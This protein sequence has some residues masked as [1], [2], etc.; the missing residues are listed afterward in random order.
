MSNELSAP[1]PSPLRKNLRAEFLIDPDLAFLNHGSFGALPRVVFEEQTRW[2]LRIEADPIEILG[3][4]APKLIEEAKAS[5]GDWLGMKTVDFGLVTNATEGIN[6]V[7][8]SLTFSA[9]DE[10]LTT[11]HVYNAVRQAMKFAAARSGAAYREVNIP[12]PV[13]SPKAIEETILGAITSRTK[14]LVVDDI[15]SPTA[16][17]FPIENILAQCEQ[18]GVDVLIDGAHGPGMLARNIE[19]LSPAYY[20]GN[21]HKWACAPKGSA[22]LWV[23]KNR[24]VGIHPLVVSHFF[25]QG[26]S[27]EFGWQGTRDIASWLSVPRAIRYMADIGWDRIMTHNHAMAV[28]ANR[29]LCAQWKV[30]SISPIDG[31]M[32]GSMTTAPLPPPLDRMTLAEA[33]KMQR[34]MHDDF[35]IEA[36]LMTWSG[37]NYVR[38]CFQIYTIAE[39]VQRLADCITLIREG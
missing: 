32:L 37:L 34:R 29:M 38:P 10:L 2:R 25:D 13:S 33:E 15:T 22:F 27:Q 30:E 36:P 4:Q 5:V 6:C 24:Q 16:L 28:W 8:R 21:L 14:L 35:R 19:K 26:L 17:V 31:S 20:S 12:L 18:R 7:L 9:G 11:N 23:R 3:R 39:D 1:P